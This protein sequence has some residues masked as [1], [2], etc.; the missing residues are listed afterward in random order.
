METI[1]LGS[2]T[3]KEDLGNVV[4]DRVYYKGEHKGEFN[5]EHNSEILFIE[6]CNYKNSIK[7]YKFY[8]ESGVVTHVQLLNFI[9][10]QIYIKVDLIGCLYKAKGLLRLEYNYNEYLEW[11]L[12][13]IHRKSESRRL[14][15]YENKVLNGIDLIKYL[16]SLRKIDL[17]Y[18]DIMDDVRIQY[19][20]KLIVNDRLV[21]DKKDFIQDIGMGELLKFKDV[22][23]SFLKSLD[24]TIKFHKF[25]DFE[26]VIQEIES[27][28]EI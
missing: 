3:Y 17:T 7:E 20:I 24:Y 10:S 22:L 5:F 12:E 16:E 25:V 1:L 2:V 11:S 6:I 18:K 15:T 27:T 13:I 19:D 26:R 28:C 4:T 14:L 9:V 23:Y 8:R 21:I